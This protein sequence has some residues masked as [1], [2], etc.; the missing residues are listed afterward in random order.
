MG[1]ASERKMLI[2]VFFALQRSEPRS[3]RWYGLFR[4]WDFM[5]CMA[6]NS[7]ACLTSYLCYSLKIGSKNI[8]A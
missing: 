7:A 2:A 5:G 1:L 4:M 8:F 3:R 6:R